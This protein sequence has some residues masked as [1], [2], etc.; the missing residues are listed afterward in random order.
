[1]VKFIH[2]E[3]PQRQHPSLA[4]QRK[5]WNQSRQLESASPTWTSNCQRTP[6]QFTKRSNQ[7]LFSFDP[8]RSLENWSLMFPGKSLK[9]RVSQKKIKH[10]KERKRV[11]RN[12]QPEETFTTSRFEP[13]L[14][15]FQPDVYHPKRNSVIRIYSLR[16]VGEEWSF[17]RFTAVQ[18]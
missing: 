4:F 7:K 11:S 5:Y 8:D 16:F 9:I 3:T 18:M 1:M 2:C 14:P 10:Q 12:F 17:R 13:N 15:F 6:Q